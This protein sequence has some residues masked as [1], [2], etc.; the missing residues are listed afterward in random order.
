[1]RALP[2]VKGLRLS[3]REM[4]MPE[5]IDVHCPYCET[6]ISGTSAQIGQL[7]SSHI[8]ECDAAPEGIRG[9]LSETAAIDSEGAAGRNA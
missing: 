2:L 5:S 3:P 4:Q 7:T 6:P 9:L 8:D 1:M